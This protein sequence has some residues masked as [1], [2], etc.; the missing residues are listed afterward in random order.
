YARGVVDD[1]AGVFINLK[2]LE[3]IFAADGRLPVNVKL[4]F[5]GEEESGSPSMHPFVAAHTDLLKADL[6]ILCDGGFDPQNP[7]IAYAGRGIISAEVTITGPDHDLH[8]GM[9]GGVVHNPI[10]LMSKIIASF[11]DDSGRI[12]IPGYYDRVV[13]LD[14]A[15]I[16]NLESVWQAISAK[17][18]ADAGVKNFWAASMGS[19]PE[20][21]TAL[22]TLEINGVYGGYQGPG[23]KTVI[24]SKAGFKVTMRLVR[25]QNPREI[26]RLFAD[27][28]R[29]F[30]TDTATIDV[31]VMVEG[32]PFSGLFDGPG[33][34]AIQRALEA[35]IGKRALMERSGGSI[36]IAGMFQQE[37]GM[38][39]T[40]FGLGSGENIHSPNEYMNAADFDK[41]L[42]ATIRLYYNLAELMS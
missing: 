36:P 42:A 1:K 29:S 33:V 24:P 4:F 12:Q 25:D 10:H 26:G 11:H 17:Y 38:P 2:A 9:Y 28:V 23:T 35:T 22:P 6:L 8:S 18:Q 27:Y 5:E 30:A 37:L 32:W 34:E 14:P 21:V 3:S 20:R 19:F 40:N 39:L 7:T 16:A 41:A 13:K 15:E 31:Q